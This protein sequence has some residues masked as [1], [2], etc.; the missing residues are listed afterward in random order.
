MLSAIAVDHRRADARGDRRDRRDHPRPGGHVLPLRP[1]QFAA[2]EGEGLDEKGNA[3]DPITRLEGHGKIE[4]FLDDD[5]EVAN[6]YLQIPELRGFEKFCVGPPGRGA[7]AHHAAHLRRVPGGAPHGRGQGRRRRLPRRVPP[8]RPRSCASCSTAPSTST[9][10]TTHFYIL[11]GPDFVVG[12]T[13]ARAERNILG[14]IDKV[15]LEI[16]KR[17]H[18][19]PRRGRRGHQHDR[20]QADPPGLRP[21]RRRQPR[22]SPRR[23]ATERR[24]H[25]PRRPSSS[26]SS[27]SSSSTT[28]CSGTRPTST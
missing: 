26:P 12:P 2:Q 3:I 15:G 11:A 28:S 10:H 5:G 6:V 16:G 21:A 27:R 7:A 13:R 4:I 1:P 22:G 18:R 17:R 20:R 25:R 19:A 24:G 8:P 9:D 23:S 14:V